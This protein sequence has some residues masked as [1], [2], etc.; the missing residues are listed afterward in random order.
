MI[1][2]HLLD[3]RARS[4]LESMDDGDR[5]D[6]LDH[7]LASGA[8][9]KAWSALCELFTAWPEGEAKERLLADADF[10]LKTWDDHLRHLSSA[11]RHLYAGGQVAS[12]ARLARYVSIYRRE[13]N[14]NRELRSIAGSPWFARLKYLTINNSTIYTG[15]WRAL[16]QSAYLQN[17]AGLVLEGLILGTPDVAA[18]AAA[19][20]WTKL[21]SLSLKNSGIDSAKI[22]SLLA[23]RLMNPLECLDLAHNLMDNA[24][25]A[26]L[27]S[28]E[29]A[30][31]ISRLKLRSNYIRDDGA[32]ALL[33]SNT[34][35]RLT[36]L[37]L[38]SNPISA[39]A[40]QL[41][42]PIAMER[43]IRLVF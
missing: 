21:T 14:G 20:S 25:A 32:R 42:G 30:A 29:R 18:I 19:P 37:D 17:L 23:A 1:F 35:K 6:L 39:D 27:A 31:Q 38:S 16:A 2:H 8:S 11:W 10:R 24:G 41:L 3:Y 33:E 22:K 34:L 5:K 4:F 12:I 28:S 43:R 13:E 15:G 26:R 9:E 36:D 7:I 40:K